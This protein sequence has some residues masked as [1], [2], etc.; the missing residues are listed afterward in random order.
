MGQVLKAKVIQG[1]YQGETVRVT[2]VSVDHAGRQHAACFLS[3]GERANIP[4]SHLEILPD[5]PEVVPQ[6]PRNPA[7]MPFVSGSIGS[8]TMNQARSIAKPRT[9]S[10][11]QPSSSGAHRAPMSRCEVC[12]KIYDQKSRQGKPG[13]VTECEEC[14]AE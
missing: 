13:P 9:I 10:T 5:A 14:A 4:V 1:R 12:G 8:R 3:N 2:N 11:S 7:S 6:G